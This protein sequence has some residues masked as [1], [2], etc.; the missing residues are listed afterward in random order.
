MTAFPVLLGSLVALAAFA[1]PAWSQADAPGAAPAGVALDGAAAP[2]PITLEEAVALAAE[3][4]PEV[5]RARGESRTSA[6]AVRSAYASFIPSVSLSAGASRQLPAEAGRTRIENGQ[7]ITLPSEPWSFNNGIGASVTLFEGGRR[8]F[9]LRQARARVGSAEVNETAQRYA[10]TLAVQQAF[11]DVL[12]ARESGEAARA[13]LEQ[14]EQQLRAATARVRAQ[15]ATRSDSLRAVIQVRSARLAA[16]Q[17]QSDEEAGRAALTRA[18]GTPY[19]VTA[20]EGAPAVAPDLALGDAELLQLALSGPAVRQAEAAVAQARAARS[21]SWA[22]YLPSITASYSRGGSGTG[23]S[24]SL[25]GADDN[26]SG[27]IR[28][29][30]SLPLF[31]QLQREERRTQADVALDNAE[32]AL[33]DARLAAR[34][35]FTQLLSVFRLAGERTDAQAATVESAAEDLRLQQR[36]YDLGAATLLDV[37]TS[38][39]Q[40]DQARRDLIRARYD[41]R[42]ARARLEALLG[43]DL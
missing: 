41:Q 31:T 6:A 23:E 17:A 30:A 16:L 24:F 39:T 35:E 5:I 43:R 15:A 10:A 13:Q 26:Y 18:V 2:R 32:A 42:V 1:V 20:A 19:A 21:A 3:N 38:Q 28:F 11:F 12:A 14:A 22:D 27:S 34:E 36:R 9:D 25:T 37:L 7:V 33:R 29:S 4:A 40:L 8:I